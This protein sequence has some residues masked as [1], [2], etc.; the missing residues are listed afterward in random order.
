M[1]VTELLTKHGIALADTKPGRYYT[2][3]P[4]CSKDRRSRTQSAKCLGVTIEADGGVR[5]GCNHCPW[6]GPEKGSGER[7]E[8]QSLRLSRRRRRAARFRKVRNGRDVSRASG[9]NNRTDAV[10]GKRERRASTPR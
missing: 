4:Q 5:W 9:S 6:T 1:T 10:A 3:C 2:T 7:Q 8:L